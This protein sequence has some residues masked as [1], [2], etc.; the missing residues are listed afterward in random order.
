MEPKP[1]SVTPSAQIVSPL[2]AAGRRARRSSSGPSSWSTAVANSLWTS[3]LTPIPTDSERMSSSQ[4]TT[5]YQWS[6]PLPPYSDPK[7]MPR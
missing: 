4:S 2:I 6:R 1:G 5:V 7:R 3:M